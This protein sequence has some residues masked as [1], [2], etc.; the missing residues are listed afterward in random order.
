[1]LLREFTNTTLPYSPATYGLLR[2]FFTVTHF[3][4]RNAVTLTLNCETRQFTAFYEKTTALCFYG[5][6]ATLHCRIR[7][8]FTAFSVPF[9]PGN[10]R[11]RL[12]T[13]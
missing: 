11:V 12:E 5:N 10:L 7:P 6:S 3:A 13:I 4:C 1:M 9:F 8:L 2:T